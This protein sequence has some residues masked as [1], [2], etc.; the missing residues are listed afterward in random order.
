MNFFLKA[1][2]NS[3]VPPKEHLLSQRCISAVTRQGE[4]LIQTS[5]GTLATESLTLK[6]HCSM[7]FI[8]TRVAWEVIQRTGVFHDRFKISGIP[9]GGLRPWNGHQPTECNLIYAVMPAGSLR[10]L[11]Q[12]KVHWC[13]M[14]FGKHMEF[15]GIVSKTKLQKSEFS[16]LLFWVLKPQ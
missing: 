15:I 12:V 13:W 8:S 9:W 6:L 11:S 5:T 14:W 4:C 1:G 7:C 2:A 16:R 10:V 3:V